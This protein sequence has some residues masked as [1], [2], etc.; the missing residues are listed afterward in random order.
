MTSVGT[1][2]VMSVAIAVITTVS[3][4]ASV[5]TIIAAI[6]P[7][8]FVATEKCVSD[9]WPATNFLRFNGRFV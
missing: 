8:V 1:S 3:V 9:F 5:V 4:V 7:V 2:I 6:V